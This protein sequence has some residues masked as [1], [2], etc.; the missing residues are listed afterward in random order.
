MSN[1]IKLV[2]A[3]AVYAGP[4]RRSWP[5]QQIHV[6]VRF[7][8]RGLPIPYVGSLENISVGGV[9]LTTSIRLRIGEQ[10]ELHIPVNANGASIAIAA[11]VARVT[12]KGPAR[13]LGMAFLELSWDQ[14]DRLTRFVERAPQ[15]VGS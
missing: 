14:L 2:P 9:C 13:L 7:T 10:I 8:L 11:S 6:P 15:V 3:P 1:V 4:E 5:R 12:E